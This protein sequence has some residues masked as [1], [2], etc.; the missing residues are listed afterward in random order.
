MAHLVRTATKTLQ[1]QGTWEF[2]SSWTAWKSAMR[3]ASPSPCFWR[4]FVAVRTRW[5]IS[6]SCYS[7]APDKAAAP[8][9]VSSPEGS[10]SHSLIEELVCP[11]RV[12]WMV[13]QLLDKSQC[14]SAVDFYLNFFSVFLG[15]IVK[16]HLLC[17]SRT[18]SAYLMCLQLFHSSCQWT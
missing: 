5:A 12:F 14:A 7:H 18:A 16:L 13:N 1:K 8:T 9:V 4:V 2:R 3:P 17:L 11:V 6:D 15:L 10:F